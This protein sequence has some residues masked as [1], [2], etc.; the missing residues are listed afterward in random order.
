MTQNLTSIIIPSYNEGDWVRWT[1]ENVLE[2]EDRACPQEVIV[3]DDGSTDGSTDSLPTGVSL[4]R[5]PHAGCA[6]AKNAG[7]ERASGDV[8]VFLDAHTYVHEGW[9]SVMR[10]VLAAPQ[11]GSAA[12]SLRPLESTN[13]TRLIGRHWIKGQGPFD[14][15]HWDAPSGVAVPLG[16]GTCQAFKRDVFEAIGGFCEELA[17]LGGEDTEISLR[18]W[19]RGYEVVAAP[20][21]EVEYLL[22]ERPRGTGMDESVFANLL[23]VHLMHWSPRRLTAMW[24][25]LSREWASWP[26]LFR[27]VWELTHRPSVFAWR[28][29]VMSE[30]V[31]SDDEFFETFPLLEREE[32]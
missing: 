20:D 19:E 6:P 16:H 31:R 30:R 3:V 7:A 5:V 8:L 17:P 28:D 26:D 23:K 12:P 32:K 11:S 25:Y 14:V 9:I 1:A 22:K 27:S 2:A 15:G 29:R 4:H 13:G 21:A 10:Q 24:E 18:L